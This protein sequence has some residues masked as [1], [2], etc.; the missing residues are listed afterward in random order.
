MDTIFAAG[1][2][3][4]RETKKD[5]IKVLLIRRV[6]HQDWSFPKGK[7]DKGESLPVAAVRETYEET[8]LAIELAVNL[9]TINY[10]VSVGKGNEKTSRNKTVQYWAAKVPNKIAKNHDFVPND[11]VFKIK[12]VKLD[13]VAKKLTYPADR[14]L[15]SVFEKL[16]STGLHDTFSITLLRHAKALPRAESTMPDS[17]RPLTDQGLKQALKIVPTLEAFGLKQI[18][19]STALR[20]LDTVAP[21]AEHTGI[22]VHPREG[23]SQDAWESGETRPL[24]ELISELV[25]KNISTVVCSHS[26]VLPDL[27]REIAAETMSAPGRYLASAVEL[28]TA[29][30][31]VFHISKDNYE[32]NQAK[33]MSNH[34][35][36][37]VS[38]IV[39]VETYPIKI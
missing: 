37:I 13:K 22:E 35:S 3:C 21:L 25:N 30:F 16:V 5:E 1:T 28:P 36:G 26:P 27:A 11:E 15:F 29:A 38:G 34:D 12:W 17:R 33:N 20:C 24:R 6:K 19:S 23:I 4:W 10:T 31:S 18:Y 8:G 7:V 9:G 2:V 32:L 39:A 14:E